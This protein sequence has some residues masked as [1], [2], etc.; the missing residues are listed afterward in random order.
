M[1]NVKA[2]TGEVS[3]SVA[4]AMGESGASSLLGRWVQRQIVQESPQGPVVCFTVHRCD[5]N[6][7]PRMQIEE[8]AVA[9]QPKLNDDK[10]ANIIIDIALA[11]DNDAHGPGAASQYAAIARR[12]A[13]PTRSASVHCFVPTEAPAAGHGIDGATL[14]N[15]HNQDRKHIERLT[16]SLVMMAGTTAT[17]WHNVAQVQQQRLDALERRDLER[18]QMIEDAASKR[19]QHEIEQMQLGQELALQDKREQRIDRGVDW[20][21]KTGMPLLLDWIGDTKKDP[22]APPD[23]KLALL[24]NMVND[25]P[26]KTKG[27]FIELLRGLPVEQGL[28]WMK[29]LKDADDAKAKAD[30]AAAAPPAT[31]DPAPPKKE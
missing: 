19:H 22:N 7:N 18:V 1:G 27:E 14:A 11:A 30:K 6:G 8:V 31:P 16:Q 23:A 21:F 28:A 4:L 13:D 5:A 10:V 29:I 20:A 12:A 24:G 25:L 3:E 9:A 17:F 26:D 2:L 15:L